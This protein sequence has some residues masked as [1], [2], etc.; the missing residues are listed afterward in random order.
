MNS[1]LENFI[2]NP[3]DERDEENIRTIERQDSDVRKQLTK[4]ILEGTHNLDEGPIDT[5]TG[6][7]IKLFQKKPEW[8]SPTRI[9]V[10]GKVYTMS[11]WE[12]S[13]FCF[14]RNTFTVVWENVHPD[15]KERLALPLIRHEAGK[16][17]MIPHR[18]MTPWVEFKG[19][20]VK[21]QLTFVEMDYKTMQSFNI[22]D[23][24]DKNRI[25]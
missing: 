18:F 25:S 2:A 17:V 9:K 24:K 20:P 23:F 19:N 14:N 6:N 16:M 4:G 11:P 13:Y 12:L 7:E 8:I 5:D 3:K 22:N 1:T 15:P 21:R 10:D